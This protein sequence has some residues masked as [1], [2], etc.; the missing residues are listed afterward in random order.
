LFLFSEWLQN[1]TRTEHPFRDFVGSGCCAVAK[2]IGRGRRIFPPSAARNDERRTGREIANRRSPDSSAGLPDELAE[3]SPEAAA[4]PQ[5]GPCPV[6][7]DSDPLRPPA[8]FFALV[9]GSRGAVSRWSAEG[10]ISGGSSRLP[11]RHA[12]IDLYIWPK[13]SQINVPEQTGERSGYKFTHW[14]QDDMVFW[15]VSDLEKSVP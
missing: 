2:K 15:A 10:L 7:A 5:E 13:S 12:R 3:E 9:K 4:D 11:P 1:R 14:N 8:G 6:Q